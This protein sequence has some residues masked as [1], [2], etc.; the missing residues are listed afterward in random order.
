MVNVLISTDQ[1]GLQQNPRSIV[2]GDL[3]YWNPSSKSDERDVKK[4]NSSV[5]SCRDTCEAIEGDKNDRKIFGE[6]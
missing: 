4:E 2:F 3:A 1:E 6:E 5:F